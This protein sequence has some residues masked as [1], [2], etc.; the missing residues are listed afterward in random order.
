[1]NVKYLNDTKLALGLIKQIDNKKV[2]INVTGVSGILK[3]AK[4]KFVEG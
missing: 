4:Q 1:V 3:K 2:I